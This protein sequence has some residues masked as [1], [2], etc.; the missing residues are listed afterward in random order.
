[1]SNKYTGHESSHEQP[2][3]LPVMVD[4]RYVLQSTTVDNESVDDAPIKPTPKATIP[5]ADK[6]PGGDEMRDTPIRAN[7]MERAHPVKDRVYRAVGAVTLTLVVWGGIASVS[8]YAVT[9]MRYGVEIGPRELLNNT[10]EVP[11]LLEKDLEK[12]KKAIDFINVFNMK[13][14]GGKYD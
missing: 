12:A 9:K 1:M 3:L 5:G 2:T 6:A 7:R 8:D 11:D 14:V 4:G 10:A 13:D